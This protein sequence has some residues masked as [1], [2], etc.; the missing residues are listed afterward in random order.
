MAIKFMKVRS[1][2]NLIF[3]NIALLIDKFAF[4]D[5]FNDDMPTE[6]LSSST[7]EIS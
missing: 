3:N 4:P 5:T 6:Y 7:I 2:R 1:P